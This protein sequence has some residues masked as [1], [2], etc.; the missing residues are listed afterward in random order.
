VVVNIL[1]PVIVDLL[2]NGGLLDYVAAEGYLILSGIIDE[3]AALVEA[4]LQDAGGQTVRRLT[5]RD[6]VT[7]IA[8]PLS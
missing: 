6:W 8:Q 7:F 3:Q 2:T 5:Q 1:A 4:A